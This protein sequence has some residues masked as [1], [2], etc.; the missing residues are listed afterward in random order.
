MKESC[1]TELI[2]KAIAFSYPRRDWEGAIVCMERRRVEVTRIQ[3][4]GNGSQVVTG[5]DLDRLAE[6]SFFLHQMNGIEPVEVLPESDE[7]C[8]V[9]ILGADGICTVPRSVMPAESASNYVGE[10][11]GRGHAHNSIAIIMP[12]PLPRLTRNTLGKVE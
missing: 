3:T 11:N 2:G 10:W 4:A 12:R 1:E 9:V 7:A 5:N 6:R 8:C